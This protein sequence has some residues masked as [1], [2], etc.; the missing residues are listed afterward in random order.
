[1]LTS[2][3]FILA[4]TIQKPDSAKTHAATQSPGTSRELAGV[5]KRSARPPD[6]ARRYTRFEL[7]LAL[8]TQGLVM[9]PWGEEKFKAHKPNVGPNPVPIKDSNDP[10]LKML[11]SGCAARLSRTRRAD[12]KSFQSAGRVVMVYEYNHIA[13]EIYMDGRKHS[14]D[15][16]PSWMG[17]SIGKWERNALVVDT[18][19]FND[20]T[21]LDYSGHPH[22]ATLCTLSNASSAP[23]MTLCNSTSRSKTR[24]HTQSPG[25]DGSFST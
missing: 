5:W 3:S 19:G 15:M 12:S 8:P 21:W 13:R 18:V 7:T 10:D 9:T 17:D 2:S 20:Q 16:V 22:P 25:E 6:N 14:E 24:K 1:M 4:R 11:S 23:I